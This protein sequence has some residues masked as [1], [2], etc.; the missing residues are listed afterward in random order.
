MKKILFFNSNRA[1]GGG[2]KWH[3]EMAKSLHDAGYQVA[4]VVWPDSDLEKKAKEFKLK[5]YSLKVH[6]VSYLFPWSKNSCRKIFK[7]FRPECTII[8]LPSDLKLC[9]RVNQ[10]KKFGKL[11][12]RRGMP[13]PIKSNQTNILSLKIL[14]KIIANSQAVRESILKNHPELDDKIKIIENAV[15]TNS[16]Q[17]SKQLTNKKIILGN[18]GR[19]VEQKGHYHLIPIAKYLKEKNL[20]FEMRIAGTGPLDSQLQEKISQQNLQETIKL[21]GY[22]NSEQFLDQIDLFLF[23]SHFEG[24]SNALIEAQSKGLPC[25]AFDISS[26]SEIVQ[27]GKTGYLIPPYDEQ[28]MANDIFNLIHSPELYNQ[29]SESS[30]LNVNQN[31]SFPQKVKLLEEIINE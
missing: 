27:Q 10:D 26:N 23:P 8:N 13:H 16:S 19:L 28:R 21:V 11:I 5:T 14:D 2:E 15:S 12:Y 4:L 6:K 29:M 30:I 17:K 22:V 3:F 1:W 9:T 25:I 31:F 24:A 18:L 7:D 20:N